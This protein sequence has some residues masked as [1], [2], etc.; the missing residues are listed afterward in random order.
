MTY[1]WLSIKRLIYHASLLLLV[2]LANAHHANGFALS[3]FLFSF[4]GIDACSLQQRCLILIISGL[5]T[6][7]VVSVVALPQTLLLAFFMLL[8]TLSTVY[9][10]QRYRR[11]FYP[12]F[13]LNLFAI[14]TMADHT[15]VMLA[16]LNILAGVLIALVLQFIFWPYQLKHAANYLTV[17]VLKQCRQLNDAIMTCLL[18]TDYVENNYFYENKLHAKKNRLL[19]ALLRLHQ[20]SK[21]NSEVM[22]LADKESLSLLLTKF[23]LLS[24]ML[25]DAMQLRWRVS[26]HSV[27]G[28]CAPELTAIAAVIDQVLQQLTAYF[29]LH[30]RPI[31]T[32][33]STTLLA[34][35]IDALQDIYQ[36]VLQVS[37]PEPLAFLLF[38]G[39]LQRLADELHGI[40]VS[41][42]NIAHPCHPREGG[43]PS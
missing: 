41:V 4:I 11:Y 30:L 38:I 40:G 21:K 32:H 12:A 34:E 43:D 31:P 23:E 36:S 24:T 35:K 25:F 26:D 28:V 42:A 14:L 10:G 37:A 5:L 17:Q 1:T 2:I 27:F 7:L 6:A 20:F 13:L 18:Q 22:Q 15:N 3:A 29:T 16:P 8:L 9:V 19:K 33:D 39:T